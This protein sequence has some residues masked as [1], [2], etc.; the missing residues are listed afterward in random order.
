MLKVRWVMSYEF[1]SKFNRLLVVQRVTECLKVGTFLRHSVY[2]AKLVIIG[3]ENLKDILT[4][5]V[6][7]PTPHLYFSPLWKPL[8]RHIVSGIDINRVKEGKTAHIKRNAFD[9]NLI[10][11]NAVGRSSSK[12]QRMSHI[13]MAAC[14]SCKMS[15]RLSFMIGFLSFMST[16]V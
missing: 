9:N 5:N 11:S 3:R 2:T 4:R 10:T 12:V 16:F 15:Q 14:W 1:C 6:Q 7:F 8:T 13:A